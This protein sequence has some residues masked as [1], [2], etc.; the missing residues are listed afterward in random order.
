MIP[1]LLAISVGQPRVIGERG[2]EQVRSGIDKKPITGSVTVGSMGVSGD[3][4]ED[5]VNHGGIDKAVYAYDRG[6]YTFWE[7]QLGRK[8]EPGTF[9]EN[10]TVE[11]LPSDLVRVGD[12][13]R[14][15]TTL[16]EVTQPRVPCYKLGMKMGDAH[17]TVAFAKALRVG[18]YLRVIE[19]GKITAGDT[20]ITEHRADTTLSIA[21]MM[22]IY[23]TG[24]HDAEKLSAIIALPELAQAWREELSERLSRLK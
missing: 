3:G 12:R 21:D 6:D 22:N 1:T 18:F 20:I 7:Q 19:P 4:Q 16:F 10:L 8:L 15:G 14:I 17:F 13:Y 24:H 2:R 23:L 9:G 11:G 5:L